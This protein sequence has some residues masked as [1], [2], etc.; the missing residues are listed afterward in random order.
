VLGAGPRIHAIPN[1]EL[2]A[3]SWDLVNALRESAGAGRADNMPAFMRVMAK[4]PRLF[5][6][7]MEMGNVLF[8][9]H[10]PAREREIAVLRISWLAGAAFE[11]G[12]HVE[13]GKRCGLSAEEI[14]RVTQ[15]S[16]APGWAEHDAAILRGVEELIA[17][18]AISEATWTVLARTWD[19]PQLIE[20]PMVVGQYLT[21][22][23]LLN[24]LLVQLGE[25]NSGLAHR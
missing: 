4:H 25:G 20:F 3:A 17:D 19:E 15:G 11:W 24:S 6:R 8:N 16:S 23:F 10:I 2:D 14:E 12:E 9:G 21:T 22:A 1:D 13:I 7:Q 5:H 18:F